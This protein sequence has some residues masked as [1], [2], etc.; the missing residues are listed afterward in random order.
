MNRRIASHV[1]VVEPASPNAPDI[2]DINFFFENLGEIDSD[3][4][5]DAGTIGISNLCGVKS[6]KPPALVHGDA[7][8]DLNRGIEVDD[9]S[10]H[11]TGE[12]L[13]ECGVDE[14]EHQHKR[15][16]AMP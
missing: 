3:S 8:E 14:A 5:F 7:D 15:L 11:I 12:A 1:T 10:R 4:S 6:Y 2:S 16:F 9:G 13:A